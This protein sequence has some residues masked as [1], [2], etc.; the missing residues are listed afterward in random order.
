MKARTRLLASFLA[1]LL[2]LSPVTVW[3]SPEAPRPSHVVDLALSDTAESQ[4]PLREA[5]APLGYRQDDWVTVMVELEEEP[6]L[7]GQ[8]LREDLHT[9]SCQAEAQRLLASHEALQEK[10][11][12][13]PWTAAQATSHEKSPTYEY[14][15]I[16]NGFAMEMCY[17]DLEALQAMPGV[18]SAYVATRYEAPQPVE[19][20]LEPMMAGSTGGIGSDVVNAMGYDGS[21]MMVAVLDTGLD[22]DHVAFA[23]APQVQ[24]LTLEELETRMNQVQL[25]AE[26]DGAEAA[27]VS[28]K[29]PYAYDY[30]SG[31]AGAEA[32]RD[33]AGHGTHV[34]GTVA[35]NCEELRGVAPNAQL[36]IMKVTSPDGSILDSTILAALED[37]VLLGVDAVN[38]SLGASA[39]FAD[40]EETAVQDAYYRCAQAGVSLMIAAGNDMNSAVGNRYGNGLP[41]AESRIAPWSA[42]RPPP[43]PLCLWPVWRISKRSAAI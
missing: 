5:V 41:L 4:L 40:T 34:A 13:L 35:G 10:I 42:H 22:T 17:G 14:T 24:T 2:C 12:R 6:L 21:G 19:T 32:V 29:I 25:H 11:R 16:F 28:G 20:G 31:E 8:V 33:S 43:L 7:N 30:G 37:A 18:K 1:L 36:L 15:A 3:A 9:A 38:M 39:G 27:Y 26:L 23:T